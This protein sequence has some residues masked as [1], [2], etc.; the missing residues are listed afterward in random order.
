MS[1]MSAPFEL[2]S[3][4]SAWFPAGTADVEKSSDFD[5]F[6]MG[7]ENFP[8]IELA[9]IVNEQKR[10]CE[11]L[12]MSIGVQEL[13]GLEHYLDMTCIPLDFANENEEA[14]LAYMFLY[15]DSSLLLEMRACNMLQSFTNITT[16]FADL[17]LGEKD[18][19]IDTVRMLRKM[20]E[21]SD[22]S[23]VS[24]VVEK[25]LIVY[26]L[27]DVISSPM[28][29]DHAM[30]VINLLDVESYETNSAKAIC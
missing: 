23:E 4:A 1:V 9:A 12:Q 27:S 20:M 11:K 22:D 30:R 28:W 24:E 29:G 15:D 13:W 14:A 3:S 16:C 18:T 7:K 17:I 2:S 26:S 21:I 19:G 10:I 5:D 8:S 6:E 25:L